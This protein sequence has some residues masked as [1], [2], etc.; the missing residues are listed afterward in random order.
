M[1]WFKRDVP[2]VNEGTDPRIRG[3]LGN[4]A[5]R[6]QRQSLIYT[7]TPPQKVIHYAGDWGQLTVYDPF[8]VSIF[9]KRIDGLYWSLRFGWRFDPNIGDGQNPKEPKHDPPGGRFL[10]VIIKP[11]IDHIVGN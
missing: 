8:F 9:L 10:D 4:I 7:T 6:L 5:A 2:Y 11:R 3:P 1:A